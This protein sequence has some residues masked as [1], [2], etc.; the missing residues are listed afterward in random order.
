MMPQLYKTV[1][2]GNPKMPNGCMFCVVGARGM[3]TSAVKRK[4]LGSSIDDFLKQ[5]CAF[6]DA[7]AV[8]VKEVVEWQLAEAM[9]QRKISP[10]E[11]KGDE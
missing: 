8:A 4:H 3:L 11:A 9:K 2:S 10:E 7:E 1:V 5:E 6:E